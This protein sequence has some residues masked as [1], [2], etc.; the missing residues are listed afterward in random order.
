LGSVPADGRTKP[1]P[2]PR[3]DWISIKDATRDQ[4]ELE[5]TAVLYISSKYLLKANK[6]LEKIN[7]L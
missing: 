4:G 1:A 6:Y 5:D 7:I 3:V 2:F